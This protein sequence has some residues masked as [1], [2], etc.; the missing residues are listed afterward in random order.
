MRRLAEAKAAVVAADAEIATLRAEV[1][2]LPEQTRRVAHFAQLPPEFLD[3]PENADLKEYVADARFQ[4]L[5]NSLSDQCRFVPLQDVPPAAAGSSGAAA[6]A[7]VVSPAAVPVPMELD[8]LPKTAWADMF[9]QCG[10]DQHKIYEMLM[11]QGYKRMRAADA[12]EPP[13]PK[14]SG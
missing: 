2:T 4:K 10:G 3:K 11:A 14:E 5:L 1:A 8:D 9:E 6:P 12:P 13:K 7:A